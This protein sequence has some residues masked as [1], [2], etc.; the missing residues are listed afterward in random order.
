V[1]VCP[2]C[3]KY[4]DEKTKGRPKQYCSDTCANYFKYKEALERIII[5]LRP[6]RKH[7]NFIKGDMFRLANLMT[8]S[9]K[10]LLENVQ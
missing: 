4:F 10:T 7:V 3:G 8:Y 9:T 6:D 2:T 1:K 5:E